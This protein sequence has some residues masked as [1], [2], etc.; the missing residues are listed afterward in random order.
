MKSSLLRFLQLIICSID[1]TNSSQLILTCPNGI[2]LNELPFSSTDIPWLSNITS[3]HAQGQNNTR[4]PFTSIPSNICWMS[5]LIV[6]F[7]FFLLHFSIY[8]GKIEY[9]SRLSI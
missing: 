6:S 5:N 7:F 9:L 8:N 2:S 3:F 4:G 1:I